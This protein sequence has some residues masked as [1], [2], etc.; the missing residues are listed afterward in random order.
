MY[1]NGKNLC[2]KMWG[3][4]YNYTVSNANYSNCLM[5]DGSI[6][7][8]TPTTVTPTVESEGVINTAYIAL[9]QLLLFVVAVML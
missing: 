5:M 9:L 1:G 2:E 7:P 3:G 6:R 4:S 8:A